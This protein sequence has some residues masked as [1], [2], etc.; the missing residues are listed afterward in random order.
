MSPSDEHGYGGETRA[1]DGFGGSGQTRTRLPERGGEPYGG[2]RRRSSS[3]SLATVMGVVVLLIAAIAFANR[4]TDDSSG[5]DDDGGGPAAAPTAPT[6]DKPVSGKN[7]A[8]PSGFGH[9]AQG[10]E[11]AAANYAVALGSA[12]MF[13][14]AARQSIAQ[15]VYTPDQAARRQADLDKVY[16]DPA[17]LRR[18][19]LEKNGAAPEGSTFVSRIIPVGTKTKKVSADTASVEVWYSSL[20]GLSGVTSKNPVSESW[21]TSTYKLKWVGN[22]WK[23]EDFS[24]KDGPVPVNGDQRASTAD[25]MSKAVEQYGGFTYAR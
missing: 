14:K 15:A 21:Y 7:G 19:G 10:A 22:D 9:D 8:I 13:D 23:V 24:Q 20:F 4:G 2:T 25:D 16:S 17:F 5:G 11:S 12:E 1:D 6:G 3:R 18:I